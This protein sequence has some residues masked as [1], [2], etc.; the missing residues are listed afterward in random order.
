MVEETASSPS[1][2]SQPGPLSVSNISHPSPPRTHSKLTSTVVREARDYADMSML[3][4]HEALRRELLEM[5]SCVPYLKAEA[6]H[7]WK[8]KLFFRW[9]RT[10]F[11]PI[12][13]GHH[14]N[15]EKIFFP[16]L[17]KKVGASELPATLSSDHE[18]MMGI[19]DQILT[20]EKDFHKASN[21]HDKIK[22]RHIV[23]N[24][25]QQLVPLMEEHFAEEEEKLIPLVREHMTEEEVDAVVGSILHHMGLKGLRFELPPVLAA[26]REWMTDEQYREFSHK[27]PALVMLLHNYVFAVEFKHFNRGLLDRIRHGER[28][29]GVGWHCGLLPNV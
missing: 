16:Q 3:I 14:A 7:L 9:Y 10:Y 25:I 18:T 22:V 5:S 12:I 17:A 2:P 23:I 6:S 28:E 20:A 21:D 15:E 29:R 19:L 13:H 27:S 8:M 11:Y 24:L 1:D 4:P 26:A